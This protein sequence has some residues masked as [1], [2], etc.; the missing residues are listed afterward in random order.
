[1]IPDRT[2]ILCWQNFFFPSQSMKRVQKPLIVGCFLNR[3]CWKGWSQCSLPDYKDTNCKTP[4]N[5]LST[6]TARK[7]VRNNKA[8]QEYF[9][10]NCKFLCYG[11]KNPAQS[12]RIADNFMAQI[13]SRETL[14]TL[15]TSFIHYLHEFGMKSV[16]YSLQ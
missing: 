12:V 15:L 13:C 4:W 8:K 10:W 1:M 16:D 11:P 6:T 2:L 9:S 7:G 14:S 3:S 5:L